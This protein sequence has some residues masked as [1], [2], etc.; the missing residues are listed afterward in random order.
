LDELPRTPAPEEPPPPLPLIERI[1]AVEQRL[2]LEDRIDAIE[3]RLIDHGRVPAQAWWRSRKGAIAVAAYV[4]AMVPI[5]SFVQ[6]EIG[7]R[8]EWRRFTWEQQAGTRQDF[9]DRAMRPGLT[10]AEQQRIFSFLSKLDADGPLQL[11]AQEQL[12]QARV[13][14]QALKGEMGTLE[15][16]PSIED[17]LRIGELRRRLGEPVILAT[18]GMTVSPG[19]VARGGSTTLNWS[20]TDATSIQITPRIGFVSPSGTLTVFPAETTEYTITVRN[21]TGSCGQASVSVLVTDRL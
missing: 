14:I 8:S 9:L 19:T 11:W 20:S 4:T 17:C 13:G 7:R 12:L 10:E 15:K 6:A 21:S 2:G 16:N 1:A 5:L 3:Q 18:A